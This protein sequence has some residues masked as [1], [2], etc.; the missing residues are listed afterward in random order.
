MSVQSNGILP[1]VLY[2]LTDS[3][4]D[5]A[6]YLCSGTLIPQLIVVSLSSYTINNKNIVIFFHFILD[7]AEAILYIINGIIPVEISGD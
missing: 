6:K 7:I 1:N 5:Y 2:Y 4:T 3:G